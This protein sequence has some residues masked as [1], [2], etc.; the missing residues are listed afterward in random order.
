MK[1]KL[2]SVILAAVMATT[3]FTAC[4]GKTEETQAPAADAKEE[5][6]APA[7]EPAAPAEDTAKEDAAAAED[8]GEATGEMVSDENFSILQDNYN[9][10]VDCYN[11]VAELYS[12]DEIAANADIE[13]A[14][15]AAADVIEEMGEITQDTLTE[16]DAEVLNSA[17][18]DILNAFAD[19]VD[20][21]ETVDSTDGDVVSDE[22]FATLQENYAALT[23]AYNAVAELYNDDSIETN[24]DIESALNQAHD[25]IE[26][27]GTIEQTSITE[28]DA[29]ALNGAMMDILEVLDAAI[30]AM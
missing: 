4:G 25:I 6:A 24:A 23:E 18:E 3:L 14:M 30:D 5:T 20:G 10:V 2:L 29:E 21:M 8:E 11:Q 26:E 17:M 27:M 12:S 22:T 19:L 1:K 15:A 16:E 7:E 13:E 28:E 9:L